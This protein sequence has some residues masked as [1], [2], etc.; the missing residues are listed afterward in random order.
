MGYLYGRLCELGAI[1]GI[2]RRR[3]FGHTINRKRKQETRNKKREIVE[4]EKSYKD[5]KIFIQ[6]N[7]RVDGDDD[8]AGE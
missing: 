7:N 1:D 6:D 5:E 8:G 2:I 3:F 4:K